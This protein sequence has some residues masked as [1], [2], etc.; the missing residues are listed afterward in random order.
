MKHRLIRFR[1]LTV[2]CI[3]AVTALTGLSVLGLAS[4]AYA[5]GTGVISSPQPPPGV[6]P[7]VNNQ[8]AGSWTISLNAGAVIT[9]GETFTVTV[10][11]STSACGLFFA[12]APAVSESGLNA[13]V[14]VT[15]LT[16]DA[17]KCAVVNPADTNV[18]TLTLTGV[19]T[20]PGGLASTGTITITSPL[21]DVLAAAH[22]G[23]VVVTATDSAG[24]TIATSV[25]TTYVAGNATILTVPLAT[26]VATTTPGIAIGKSSQAGGNETIGLYTAG[27]GWQSGDTLVI[28]VSDHGG[29]NC[30]GASPLTDTVSF[31]GT[32]AATA[33]VNSSLATA[34]PTFTASLAATGDCLGS[35]VDNNLDLTFG[36]TGAISGGTAASPAVTIT[37]TGISYTLGTGVA[38]GTLT[39]GLDFLVTGSS[40]PSVLVAASNTGSPTGPSDANVVPVSFAANVPPVGIQQPITS[41]GHPGAVSD[42][43][44]SPFTLTEAT[45]GA[46]AIGT[47]CFTITP[48]TFSVGGSTDTTGSAIVTTTGSFFAVAAGMGVT[49][50]GIPAATTVASVQSDTHITLSAVATSTNAGITLTFS[51]M[52]ATFDTSATMT[53][54]TSSGSGASAGTPTV[55]NS[56]TD[57]E[58]SFPVTSA[59]TTAATYTVSGIALDSASP[60]PESGPVLVEAGNGCGTN[61]YGGPITAASML[62]ATQTY[63]QTMDD[64]AAS[65]FAQSY[66]FALDDCPSGGSSTSGSGTTLLAPAV[67]TTDQN[68]P[69]ALSASYLAGNLGTGILLTP[70][71]SLSSATI[72]ALRTEGIGQVFVVGGPLA[73]SQNV[74]NQLKA[75]TV[76]RCGGIDP[77]ISTVGSP[78]TMEVTQIY[79]QTE[80]DTAADVATYPG[81]AVGSADIGGAYGMYNDTT[82]ASSSSGP[83]FSVS[84]AVLATGESFPDAMSAAGMAYAQHFPVLLTQADSLAPQ[85]QDA[86]VN[87]A[88]HQVILMGGPLAVS[89]SVVTTLQ[90]MGIS[91]LRVA[92]TDATDTA[93][94]LAQFEL[95]STNSKGVPDGLDWQAFNVNTAA[96]A[97][98]DFYADALAGCDVTGLSHLPLILTEDSSTLGTYSTTLLN[99]AGSG[100]GSGT[101]ALGGIDGLGSAGNL[102]T[103]QVFGGPLAVQLSTISAALNAISAG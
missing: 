45:A 43:P 91:V 32:P 80:Y 50:T 21:Y 6:F 46:V 18:L 38:D 52:P 66:P 14:A 88:V 23:E 41:S 2:S 48:S 86:L 60:T 29:N 73:V 13:T 26:M 4:S 8:A 11:D 72:G 62:G 76:Y 79:G 99:S 51:Y 85:A 64:T 89:D 5:A 61:T 84:T 7:G 78:F 57:T 95:N 3:A 58:I 54:A 36:N 37:L 100:V 102:Y 39:L 98:G 90:G 49:G 70:T 35:S 69:D 30:S 74:I 96:L 97:R 31:T 24:D 53:V 55:S 28:P 9:N 93:S 94:E 59:S 75:L 81:L 1:R 83:L 12:A 33:V 16:A 56:P 103:I 63:G 47:V 40:T 15:S 34:A 42:Q 17:A 68:F 71:D 22:T 101:T 19:G 20:G 25:G 65:E 27:T 82:G 87:L 44:I 77:V 92:G 67:L 10:L